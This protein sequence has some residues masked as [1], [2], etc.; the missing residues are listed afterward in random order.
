MANARSQID[1]YPSPKTSHSKVYESLGLPH[2]FT[3]TTTVEVAP[4]SWDW[5]GEWLPRVSTPISTT[6]KTNQKKKQGTCQPSRL[7]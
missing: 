1:E 3:I 7:G 2:K 4:G 5:Y 6:R